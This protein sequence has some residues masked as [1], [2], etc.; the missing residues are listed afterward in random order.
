VNGVTLPGDPIQSEPSYASALAASQR[1]PRVR[2]LFDN[3]AGSSTAGNP[4]PGFERSFST[5][6]IPGTQVRSWYFGGSGTLTDAKPTAASTGDNF[7]WNKKA[8]PPTDFTGDTG[9]GPNGLWNAIP[10]YNWTQNPRGTAVSYVS[11]PLAANTTIV[12]AG[13]VQVWI[14]SATSDVDLQATVTEVRPDGKETF[15]QSGWLR[16]SRR[17]LTPGSSILAPTPTFRRADMRPL[18]TGK[19]TEVTIPLYYEGHAY[20]KGSR[21]RVILAAPSGDNPIWAFR[22]TVPSSGADKIFIAH[23]RSMPSRLV[24]PLVPGVSV[25]TGL[26]PCPGMRGE[27]CRTYVPTASAN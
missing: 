16:A 15:V 3:G 4:V 13:A 6:P 17:K 24:L 11:G 2:V 25:P 10:P 21:V 8:R 27:P 19:F 9:G 18:P 7:T 12:G 22:N 20:R 26:P 5:F 23:S 1:L 14:K